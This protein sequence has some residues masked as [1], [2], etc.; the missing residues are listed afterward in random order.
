MLSFLKRLWPRD[1][2]PPHLHV[3]IDDEGNGVLCDASICRPSRAQSYPFSP[4]R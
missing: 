2:L 1:P 3:H 4:L